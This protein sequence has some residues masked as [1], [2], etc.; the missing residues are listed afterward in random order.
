MLLDHPIVAFDIETI[1]DPEIGRRLFGI[2]GSDAEVVREMVRRRLEETDNQSEYPQ[3]PWHRI[4]AICATLLGPKSGRVEIRSLDSELGDER[5]LLEAFFALM[6]N[7]QRAPRLVSWNGSGFDLPVIRYRAM[8]HGIAAPALYRT[9]GDFRFNNYQ[10]RYHDL[11]LDLMDVLSGHGASSRV[12]LGN[13][14]RTI[15]LPGKSFLERSVYEHVL[16]GELPRVIEYC[17]LDT[18]ETLLA[19]LVFAHHRGDL[20]EAELRQHVGATREAMAGQPYEGWREIE[21]S[22]EGWPRWASRPRDGVSD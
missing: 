9:D 8:L 13:W 1:P 19:F 22:L 4:V 6:K 17:K 2:E 21:A 3:P 14:T 18:V 11:H 7:E 16:A 15:G 10:N 12:G 20:S 5:A